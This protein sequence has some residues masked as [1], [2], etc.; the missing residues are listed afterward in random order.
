MPIFKVSKKAEDDLFEI[1]EYTQ[2][3]WG[4][5]QRN[6]YLD[7]IDQRFHQLAENPEYPIS[8]DRSELKKGIF[9]LLINEHII[10]YRK[11]SYGVRIV[12]ILNQSMDLK[13]HL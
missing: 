10:L 7:D 12:R 8:K 4:I 5:E 6:K 9:S 3:K 11:F 13:S 2:E 1:G